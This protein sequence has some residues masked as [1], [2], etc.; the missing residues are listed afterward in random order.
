MVLADFLFP[1]TILVLKFF[2]KVA[3]HK[4][5]TTTQFVQAAL[6]IPTDMMFL[7]YSFC[8]AAAVAA[9]RRDQALFDTRWLII[10]VVWLIILSV[11]V[12][13]SCLESVKSYNREGD[14]KSL[15]LFCIGFFLSSICLSIS[16]LLV[17]SL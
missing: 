8:A 15:G 6:L 11:V 3:V 14:N 13:I 1:V 4:E 2:F 7:C 12:T 10:G 5:S 17:G 9:Q 16:T